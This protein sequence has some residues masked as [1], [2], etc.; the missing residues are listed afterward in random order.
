[1]HPGRLR[2]SPP[3]GRSQ[4][5]RQGV[6]A[7]T[8]PSLLLDIVCISH[9]LGVCCP[10]SVAQV[11]FL[12]LPLCAVSVGFS[13]LFTSTSPTQLSLVQH[14]SLR[15]ESSPLAGSLPSDGLGDRTMSYHVLFFIIEDSACT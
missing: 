1:M 2:P 5:H 15:P 14:I 6:P 11:V 13:C 10:V 9:T 8:E 4:R 12:L 7:L 3:Q